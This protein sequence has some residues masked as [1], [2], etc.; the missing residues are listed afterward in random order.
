[1][2]QDRFS[3]EVPAL[4]HVADFLRFNY[5]NPV[6]FAEG[7]MFYNYLMVAVSKKPDSESWHGNQVQMKYYRDMVTIEVPKRFYTHYGLFLTRTNS[8]KLN[9][10]VDEYIKSVVKMELI[11][12]FA[13]TGKKEAGFEIAREKLGISAETFPLDAI[14]KDWQR[15]VKKKPGL[16]SKKFLTQLSP[17]VIEHL[18]LIYS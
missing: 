11:T 1:M 12:A 3:I 14:K 6:V 15:T 18:K 7:D 17:Q 10:F 5:G 4:P 2:N 13:V 8:I 16:I 9:R